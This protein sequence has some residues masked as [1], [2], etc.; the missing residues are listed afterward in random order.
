MPLYAN[1]STG[2]DLL[3]PD[4][5]SSKN[6]AELKKLASCAFRRFVEDQLQQILVERH[7]LGTEQTP[8][9]HQQHLK[10]KFPF[11]LF[12]NL[13]CTL[14]S[15]DNPNEAGKFTAITTQI[16]QEDINLLLTKTTAARSSQEAVMTSQCS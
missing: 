8:T 4:P 12:L 16:T 3:G 1:F 14:L 9:G 7:S 11:L 15:P 2:I 5:T 10:A 13:L 6:K